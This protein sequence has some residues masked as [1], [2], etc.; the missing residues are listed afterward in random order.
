VPNF[1][2]CALCTANFGFAGARPRRAAV[3]ARWK[4]DLA[5]SSSLVL[6]PKVPLPL[7]KLVQDLAR[8][9]PPP[10]GWNASSELFLS[11]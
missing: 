10:H 6:V 9:K 4:A 2:Y 11:A 1:P 8:L 3:L 5:R 7:L